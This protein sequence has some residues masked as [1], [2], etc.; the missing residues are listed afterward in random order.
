[1]SRVPI[2]AVLGP[3]AS[4]KSALALALAARFGGEIVNCDSLQLYRGLDIGTAKPTPA[5]R[6]SIPHHLFDLL[7][8]TAVF[9]AGDYAQLAGQTIAA[10]AARGKLPILAGGTGFYL[11]ALLDGLDAIPQ[12]DETLRQRLMRRPPARLHRLLERLDPPAAAR[13]HPHDSQKLVR[14]LEIRLLAGRPSKDLYQ[15]ETRPASGLAALKIVLDPPRPALH[16]RIAERTRQMFAAGLLDEVRALLA[17]GL[18]TTAKAFESIG[19]RQ[20]IAV[21]EGRLS[22]ADAIESTLINTRQYA[23]RQLTWFRREPGATWIHN[24]GDSPTVQAETAQS[25]HLY[26]AEFTSFT[27]L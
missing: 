11:R 15:P 23:K 8:P 4:G 24:F 9:S 13:I 19:Y 18:P 7:E 20:A 21:I 5:E 10:I 27:Q 16:A 1:M 2:I 3:T 25:A 14:A 17:A 22:V 6:G 12:R 26:L